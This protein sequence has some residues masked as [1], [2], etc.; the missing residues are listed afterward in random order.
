MQ[1]MDKVIIPSEDR[2]QDIDG[3]RAVAVLIVLL[4]HAKFSDWPGGFV[5]VDVFFVI[6]GYLIIPHIAAAL[7][8]GRFHLIEFFARRIRRLVPALVPVL[9]FCFTVALILYGSAGMAQ[10]NSSL[11]GAAA[12]V[13]N[14]VFLSQ[15]GYFQAAAEDILLLHTWSL[16]VEFQ[17][18]AIIPLIFVVLYRYL[19]MVMVLASFGLA[20]FVLSIALVQTGHADHAFY[21]I[22]PRFWELAVGGIIGM[23]RLPVPQ[24][25]QVGFAMRLSGFIVIGYA[26]TQFDS[27]MPFPGFSALLPVA[28]AALVLAAPMT[29]GEPFLWALSSKGMNWIGLRSYSIYLWHWPL[30]VLVGQVMTPRSKTYIAALVISFILA[31]L[32]YRFIETPVRRLPAWKTNTRLAALT[33]VPVAVFSAAWGVVQTDVFREAQMLLPGASQRY[34]RDLSYGQRDEYMKTVHI[35]EVDGDRITRGVQCSMDGRVSEEDTVNC[36]IGDEHRQPVLVIGDSH[37]RDTF[38]ALRLGFPQTDFILLHHSSCSPA[39]YALP[40]RN[41]VCFP[42][43][44]RIL[45]AFLKEI[46][47]EIVV[48]SSQWAEIGIENLDSTLEFLS[49]KEV[50]TI[51]IGPTPTFRLWAP[52]LLVQGGLTGTSADIQLKPAD[53]QFDVEKSDRLLRNKI[54]GAGV[55]YVAVL[56]NFCDTSGCLA[57]VPGKDRILMYW[58]NQHLT[59]DGMFWLGDILTD[60]EVLRREFASDGSLSAAIEK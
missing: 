53:F 51:I 44:L 57:F 7:K 54:A 3:L 4:F 42:G 34:V 23:R 6:S 10:F 41:K 55:S 46:P 22:L 25:V 9:I 58:D 48:L 11:L 27:G 28:G 16:G 43:L 14:Y 21:G 59:V 45:D 13:S 49:G 15:S 40:S 35:S 8:R 37:G 47:V 19:N 39:E 50:M 38:H 60:D 12:F 52:A 36:L 20:S 32:S 26:A 2:R 33:V 1:T 24:T 30:I 18:Y 17:F 56:H 31:D 29:K 5:G